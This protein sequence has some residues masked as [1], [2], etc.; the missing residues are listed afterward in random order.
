MS[1]A[2]V[3]SRELKI[4]CII[5]TKIATESINDGDL[6]DVDANKGIIKIIKKA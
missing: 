5:G 6:I 2:S 4:P 3:I 1:H